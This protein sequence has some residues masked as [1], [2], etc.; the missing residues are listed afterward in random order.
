MKRIV[1][2]AAFA[3]LAVASSAQAQSIRVPVAGKSAQQVHADIVMAARS[4][5]HRATADESLM[6]D[7]YTRCLSAT[8]KA[9]VAQLGDPQVAQLSN[10]RVVQR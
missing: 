3:A 5:C 1:T 9:S 6:L 7:A 4:V 2:L 8:V 10:T